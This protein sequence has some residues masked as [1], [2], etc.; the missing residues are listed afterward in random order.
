MESG[1]LVRVPSLAKG[2]VTCTRVCTH[3]QTHT[4]TLMKKHIGGELQRGRRGRNREVERDREV[5]A[6]SNT[7]LSSWT[8]FSSEITHHV[9]LIPLIMIMIM[10]GQSCT[11]TP[12]HT[13]SNTTDICS[14]H[15]SVSMAPPATATASDRGNMFSGCPYYSR[16]RDTS[17]NASR[18]L[19]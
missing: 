3:M 16:E 15:T 19:P 14:P 13:H 17:R 8:I 6:C 7:V 4:P 5:Q 9:G 11:H 10:T 2:P 1:S 18:E 12:V